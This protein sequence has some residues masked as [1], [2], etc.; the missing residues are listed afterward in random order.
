MIPGSSWTRDSKKLALVGLLVM[1]AQATAVA[2]SPSDNPQPG[3][4]QRLE[5][6]SVI[7]VG[8]SA[9]IAIQRE[10]LNLVNA[11]REQAGVAPLVISDQ[12]IQAAQREANDLARMGRLS[13]VG[14]DG[15]TIQTRVDDTGYSW[16]LIGENI[17]MGQPS[18]ESVMTAWMRSQGHRQNILN[19]A[20]SELGIAH[21]EAG[22]QKYWVQVFASPK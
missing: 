14:S 16:A 5:S 1:S 15:S 8:S 19:P 13:H 6:S 22:G 3:E 7:A 20:F 21:V 2:S 12:L 9:D 18:S 11:E 10:L 17:A 4:T